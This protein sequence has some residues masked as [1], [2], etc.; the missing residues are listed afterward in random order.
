MKERILGYRTAGRT[1]TPEEMAQVSGGFY[2]ES[3]FGTGPSPDSI[4]G[5]PAAADDCTS[6]ME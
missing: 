4:S 1:L 5:S 2:T 3:N 6:D